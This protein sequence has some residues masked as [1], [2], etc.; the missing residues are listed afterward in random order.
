MAAAQA[1]ENHGDEWG[2][3][4]FDEGYIHQF[5]SE[6]IHK[7]HKQQQ[8]HNVSRYPMECLSNDPKDHPNQ[9]KNSHKLHN[10]MG[11][12]VLCLLESQ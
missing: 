3:A 5:Q 6:P 7:I 4:W 8:K 9:H 1:A 12:S 10:E 11:H 2:L